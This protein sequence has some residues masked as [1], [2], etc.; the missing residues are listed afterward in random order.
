L[1]PQVFYLSGTIL[2]IYGRYGK[3]L[4]IGDNKAIVTENVIVNKIQKNHQN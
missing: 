1:P 2:E 3:T 4:I